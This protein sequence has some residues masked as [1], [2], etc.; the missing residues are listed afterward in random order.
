MTINLPGWLLWGFVSTVV[1]TTVL[2]FSQ[3]LRF[4]R[5][6]LPYILGTWYSPNRDRAKAIGFAMHLVN[7]WVFS[8]VYVAAFTSWHRATWWNGAAIGVVH[9]AFM[10]SAGMKLLPGVHPR[11]ASEQHGPTV[12]RQLEPP[13][14]LAL[15]YGART[16]L[17]ILVAHVAFGAILGAFYR[18]PPS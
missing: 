2:S 4:T 3:G 13:G 9:A 12:T 16:P 18:L 8:L 5:I 7:G 11:M 1:L 10:L 15:N 6:N 14:W 17:S